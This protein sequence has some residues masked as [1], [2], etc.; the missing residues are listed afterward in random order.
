MVFLLGM[1]FN[2]CH[3]PSFLDLVEFLVGFDLALRREG[4]H[5]FLTVAKVQLVLDVRLYL[6]VLIA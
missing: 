5:A 3:S 1:A 2:T 6:F 4:I